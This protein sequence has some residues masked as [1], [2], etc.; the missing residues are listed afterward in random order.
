MSK[1]KIDEQ[2][3]LKKKTTRKASKI[4]YR[5]IEKDRVQMIQE[6]LRRRFIIQ[7]KMKDDNNIGAL[8]KSEIDGLHWHYYM[9]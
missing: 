3:L 4:S 2:K 6:A 1:V 8:R 9:K 7:N 5:D